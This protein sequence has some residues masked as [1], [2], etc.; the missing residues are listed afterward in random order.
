MPVEARDVEPQLGGIPPQVFVLERR[1]AMEEQLMH[2]P[3]AVAA[4]MITYAKHNDIQE[5]AR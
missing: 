5:V 3:E 2:L 4:L 1:L